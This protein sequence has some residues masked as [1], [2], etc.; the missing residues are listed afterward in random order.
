MLTIE[1]GS[2]SFG[3]RRLWSGLNLTV[4]PGEFLAVV[5]ANGSGKTSL[6]QVILGRQRLTTGTV[7]I[8][9]RPARRGG[10]DIGYVQQ[11]RRA[12]PLTPLRAR[13]LVGQGLDGHRWG[14]GRPSAA[15]RRR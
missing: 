9:G 11:Q 12:D 15:R 13:D 14:I 6:L 2:L 7:T 5:G 3:P 4:G 8:A 10:R 1:N